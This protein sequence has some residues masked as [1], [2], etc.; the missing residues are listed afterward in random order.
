MGFRD[1]VFSQKMSPATDFVVSP[2]T[3]VATTARIAEGRLS[4]PSPE[5]IYKLRDRVV[6]VGGMTR[7]SRGGGGVRV[8]RCVTVVCGCWWLECF[9]QVCV[10]QVPE[11]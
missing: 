6:S 8:V 2:L 9:K 1:A 5:K 3:R 10:L 7:A 4:S 11:E